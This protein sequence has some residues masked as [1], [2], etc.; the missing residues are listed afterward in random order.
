MYPRFHALLA[1]SEF[2]HYLLM[3]SDWARG[4]PRMRADLGYGE[5]LFRVQGNQRR[6]EVNKVFAEKTIWLPSAVRFP[7]DVKLV[8][9]NEIIKLVRFFA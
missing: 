9:S 7:K 4:D 5:P 3:S 8:L 2:N 6:E 1:L